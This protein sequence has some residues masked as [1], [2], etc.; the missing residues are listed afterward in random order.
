MHR[1]AKSNS[2]GAAANPF[3]CLATPVVIGEALLEP[4]P[5]ALQDDPLNSLRLL[6]NLARIFGGGGPPTGLCALKRTFLNHCARCHIDV[7]QIIEL[8][9]T[10]RFISCKD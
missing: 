5:A 10:P 6:N 8:C 7:N 4:G 9:S 1:P 2:A 3:R